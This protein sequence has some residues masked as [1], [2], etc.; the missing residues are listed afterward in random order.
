MAD[1]R[2]PWRS[3]NWAIDIL[4]YVLRDASVLRATLEALTPGDFIF[5][6]ALVVALGLLGAVVPVEMALGDPRDEMDVE[7]FVLG[8][9]LAGPVEGEA[10]AE[11][12]YR[13]ATSGAARSAADRAL[14]C[15]QAGDLLGVIG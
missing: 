12:A 15:L 8:A 1:L 5:R 11:C 13:Y 7:A 2:L 10:A 14:A 9:S 3:S 6:R 4:G